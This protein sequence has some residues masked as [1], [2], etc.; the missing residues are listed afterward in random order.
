MKKINFNMRKCVSAWKSSSKKKKTILVVVSIAGVCIISGSV[1]FIRNQSNRQMPQMEM[2]VQ[3]TA[4]SIGDISNTIVG[5]GNL[6]ADDSDAVTI[7]SGIVI[8]EVKV[9]SGDHVSKGDVLAVV[10]QASVLSAMSSVQAE[11]ESLDEEMNECSDDSETETVTAKVAGRI[12]KIYVQSGS[13]AAQSMVDNSALMLLSLDGK[14][15]VDLEMTSDMAAG[16][17][18]T[19]T[20]TDGTALEGTIE[21]ISGNVCTVTM[22]DSSIS[23]DETVNV[24]KT[25]GTNIGSGTVYIH[26]KLGITATGGTVSSVSVSENQEVSS[27]TTLMTLET[28]EK[29]TE[30][31]ELAAQREALAES[32]QKLVALSQT[33]TITADIDG[34]VGSVNVTEGSENTASGSSSTSSSSS[35]P[36]SS[37][38]YHTGSYSLMNLSC[39]T[40]DTADNT[41]SEPQAESLES[42]EEPVLEDTQKAEETDTEQS[43]DTQLQLQVVDAGS[44]T[45]NTLALEAPVTGNAPQTEL[46]CA[47]GSYTGEITWNPGDSAFAGET[48]YQADVSLQAA[49]GYV[50]G[51]DSILQIQTG[52][53]SGLMV[54]EDG[55]TMSF[56]VTFPATEAEQNKQ[57][58]PQEEQ[59]QDA[60]NQENQETQQ[61]SEEQQAPQTTDETTKSGTG[62]SAGSSV[63]SGSAAQTDS[64]SG[65]LVSV[66]ASQSTSQSTSSE[67]TDSNTSSYSTDVTA[68]TLASD[69]SMVLSVSVD[70]LD[71]NSVS[72][73]QEAEVTLDAIE[74]AS[75]T[76]TVTKV[77]NSASSSGSGVAKYTV[78]ITIPKD[79]QMKDGMNASATIVIENKEDVVTIPVN[80]LQEKGDK[81]FVYT[82]KSEDGTLGGEQEVTTGLSDG[83]NVEITEGLSEGDT[84]YYQKVGSTSDSSS[85]SGKMDDRMQSGE[86][87]DMGQMPSGG[88]QGAPSGM[89]SGGMGQGGQQ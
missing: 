41:V 24:T 63:V 44:S 66:S 36:A 26:E 70:E 17:S 40:G 13:D 4:A 88:S 59:K 5:T 53:L 76:G 52:L 16:D 18:V 8:D 25:D 35:I 81:V 42:T 32:L 14:M 74:D 61:G 89:P 72:K 23:L 56:H 75:F 85:G 62:A 48:E 43:Q 39:T 22:D 46:A 38:A 73:E 87:P 71:I 67:S 60:E 19:V 1:I 77:S 78:E 69:D 33:G 65:N 57:E 37:M 79:E 55:K 27:G 31:R 50:F 11:I 82:E 58:N 6:V 30:Y 80:A 10:N 21:S 20:K 3:E 86:M 7:P 29:S 45:Q 64:T 15:A 54:S 9:E 68:F 47:D 83:S 49:E 84:V 2:S 51:S 28:D 12:K 34:T